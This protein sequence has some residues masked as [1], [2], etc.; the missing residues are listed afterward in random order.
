MLPAN[1]LVKFL[2]S[3]AMLRAMKLH[4]I[5]ISHFIVNGTHIHMIV[6]VYDPEDIPGFMERFKTESA[7]YIN[8][9]LGRKKRKVWCERYDSPRLLEVEDVINKIA[10]LYTNPVKDGLVSSINNYPGL[11][12]WNVY[13]GS[14]A[15]MKSRLIGRE[16]IFQVNQDLNYISYKKALK[17]L[18]DSKN[19]GK[20]KALNIAPND[21]MKAFNITE[22]EEVREINNRINDFIKTTELEIQIKRTEDNKP[23]LG[24]EILK[25][26]GIDLT[27]K[28]KRSGRRMWCISANKDLRKNYINYLKALA[29]RAREVYEYWQKGAITQKMP[30]GTFSPAPPVLCNLV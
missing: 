18:L 1:P 29:N 5:T 9:L 11:S 10:Y 20:L 25:N 23:F 7:H 14:L 16:L 27:Y 13:Q 12:S 15:S 21:W 8:R 30:I 22:E 17:R 26:Q 24:K 19:S 4:P 3:S 28:S 2:I 6:R